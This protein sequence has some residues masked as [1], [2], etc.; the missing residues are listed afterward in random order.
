MGCDIHPHVEVRRNGIWEHHDWRAPLVEGTYNDGS[1]RT[2]YD[3]LFVHPLYISRNYNLFAIL[4]DVRNGYGF[5]GVK[6]GDRYKPI[7]EPRGL[8]DDASPEVVKE[9]V[10]TVDNDH[11]P[12]QLQDWVDRG[13]SERINDTTVTHPDYH[14]MSYLTLAELQA[15]DWKQ[16]SGHTGLVGPGEFVNF[17]EKGKP[18]SWWGGGGYPELTND[19]MRQRTL[20]LRAALQLAPAVAYGFV[21][22]PG[23]GVSTGVASEWL[24]E[25]GLPF[26]AA[27]EWAS[28]GCPTPPEESMRC[29]TR[30]NWTSTCAD[31][32]EKFVTE[33]MPA[34]AG[35]GEP[36]DVRLVF[37]FD[38]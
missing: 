23:D 12:E 26:E 9:C 10:V 32:V 18:E 27:R 35:L 5:A 6:T 29:S 25:S 30:I 7:S 28:L 31:D 19:E 14:S 4:A 13:L 33:T 15:Y 1:P 37:W 38:N 8:P 16:E 21:V 36:D 17:L 34:L 24:E 11:S 2:N 3:A 22:M 20:H